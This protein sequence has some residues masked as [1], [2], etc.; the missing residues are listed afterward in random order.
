M[1]RFIRKIPRLGTFLKY[2]FSSKKQYFSS[3]KQ[4]FSHERSHQI[5]VRSHYSIK[6]SREFNR[7]KVWC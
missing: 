7:C 1:K 3:K 5:F 6:F 4:Y 2:C